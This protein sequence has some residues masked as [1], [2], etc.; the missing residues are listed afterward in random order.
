VAKILKEYPK[1]TDESAGNFS[2]TK[3]IPAFVGAWLGYLIVDFLLHAVILASWWHATETYWLP[4][5]ELFRR[6]PFA[7]ASFAIYCFALTWLIMRFHSNNVQPING[8]QFG[9]LAGM[10][11]GTVYVLGTYS[12]FPMP[13]LVLI[14]W[15]LS[16][17][18]ESAIAGG[19]A[20]WIMTA[21][22]PWKQVIKVFGV[23]IVFFILGVVIQ[24]L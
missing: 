21:E 8:M 6:I 11:Y 23:S 1:L 7:Y 10:V 19:I 4:Q 13:S 22:H 3:L 12:V 14:L 20:A 9:A 17:V 24:N 18:L 15:P 2:K 16:V 5:S